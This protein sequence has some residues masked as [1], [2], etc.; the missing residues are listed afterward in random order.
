MQLL[1]ADIGTGTQ[2][3]YLYNSELDLEN[4]YKLILPSP[5]MMVYMRVKEATSR[6]SP[7]VLSGVI[8]GGGPSQWAVQAHL[9]AGLPVFSTQEAA[10]SFNDDLEKVQEMGIKIV[11][12]DEAAQ[13]ARK[14]G[15]TNI[16]LY[17]F[18]FFAIEQA[19][20]IFGASLNDLEAIA[21]GV[22]DHG[23]A[24]PDY[25]DRQFRFD[26]LDRVIRENNSLA[27]FAYLA[28]N[29]PS[30]M[31]RLKA[32]AQTSA[33]LPAQLIVMDTA[34]AAALGALFD[35]LVRDTRPLIVTNVGNFHTIAFR[36]GGSGI[37]GV[38][39][40]HTGLIDLQKLDSLL[41][42]LA[43]STL[44]HVDVYNDQGHGALV[45]D[46]NPI[47]IHSQ[48][49]G[50][51]ATGPRRSMLNQSIL[52]PHFAAPFGDMMISGCFGLLA[53]AAKLLPD[54]GEQILASLTG[55]G[56]SGTPPWEI[57]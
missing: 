50:I 16:T 51:V 56:G 7:L 27:S 6:K 40:H 44:R 46:P 11:S 25:S 38:F 15:Y 24:P 52:H 53:A 45:Y 47:D 5:T 54:Q 3:I 4:N 1:A 41:A 9:E 18:D 22:F 10:K 14:S 37:E 55:F 13:L 29:I 34:P 23:N 8:M 21:V 26:Y 49:F 32:V 43:N 2:D 30:I 12:P 36:L 35:P 33:S 42:S 31:T 48:P 57:Y 20:S 17:D 39:E 28:Q 19:F